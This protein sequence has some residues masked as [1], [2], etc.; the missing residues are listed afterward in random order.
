MTRDHRARENLA[1]RALCG[2]DEDIRDHLERVTQDNIDRGMTP[3]EARRQALL[4]FGSVTLA[5]EDTRA[6]WVRIWLEQLAQDFRYAIRMVRHSPAFAVIVILTLGL[7]IGANTAIFSLMDQVLLRALPVRAPSEL[8]LLDTPGVY[9]GR[10]TGTQVMSVPMFR[11]LHAASNVVLSGMFA[12][13]DV[14]AAIAVGDSD[15]ELGFA[16]LVSGDYF[17]TLGVSALLGR[18]LGPE[19]DRTPGGHP[20]AVLTHGFWQRRFAGDPRVLGR[21]VRINGRSMTIVGVVPPGFTGVDPGAPVDLFVPL[22]MKPVLTPSWNDLESWRSRW[23]TVMGRL[24]PGVTLEKAAA[25]LNVRY[26]Q[27]LREDAQTARV[28]GEEREQFLR[29]Q[30]V[31]MP[32]A[33]GKSSFRTRFGAPLIVLMAMVALVLLIACANVANLMLARAAARQKDIALRLALGASRWRIVSQRLTESAVLACGG[34]VAGLLFASWTTRLLIETL[35]SER[36][37]RALSPDLDVRVVMFAIAIAAVTALLSGLAPTVP[38]LGGGE[39]RRSRRRSPLRSVSLGEAVRRDSGS[40]SSSRRWR[41][42]CCCWPARRCSRAAC[43]IC[44]R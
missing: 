38:V 32:G 17:G 29:T 2:L 10:T 40:G 9:Q 43:T 25:A 30:L 41:C 42:R 31:V 15:A 7:G 37:A 4:A 27:L 16:E 6:V 34:A 1:Q 28:T 23:V 20:V 22:M 3:A 12:R 24:A 18:T 8:V 19:D 33:K 36:A 11:G 21:D 5:K 39:R 14:H 26:G 13:F 35:P 44:G